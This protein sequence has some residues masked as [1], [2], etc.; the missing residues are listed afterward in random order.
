MRVYGLPAQ[1]WSTPIIEAIG[2]QYGNFLDVALADNLA[3]EWAHVLV[4][5]KENG[6]ILEAVYK[7]DGERTY[8]I[9]IWSED[10]PTI[11]LPK[12]NEEE[13]GSYD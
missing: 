9:A 10:G 2:D 4:L 3:I 6:H 13:V 1:L 12:R 8:H 7:S 11:V 5:V